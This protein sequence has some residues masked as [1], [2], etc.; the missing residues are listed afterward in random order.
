[1]S[2]E[3]DIDKAYISPYDKFLY[4]FDTTHKKTESQLREIAKHQRL[5]N[6]R[7]NENYQDESTGIWKDF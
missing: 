4:E 2:N 5:A 3:I 7:D 6:K 1:M